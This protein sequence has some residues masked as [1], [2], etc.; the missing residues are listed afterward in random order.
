M[1]VEM[2]LEVARG[3]WVGL[4]PGEV[5]EKYPGDLAA[6]ARDNEWTGHGGESYSQLSHR[7]TRAVK[8]L[9]ST[10]AENICIVTHC[11]VIKVIVAWV[12]G[13]SPTAPNLAKID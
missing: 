2:F 12:L 9:L 6:F 11:F 8:M 13:M 1:V 7:V 4:T 3:R 10:T 5:E